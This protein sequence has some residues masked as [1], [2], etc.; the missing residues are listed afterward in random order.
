M[1]IF[2]WGVSLDCHTG[3]FL[4]VCGVIS[5]ILGYLYKDFNTVLA[6]TSIVTTIWLLVVSILDPSLMLFCFLTYIGLLFFTL[7][8]LKSNKVSRANSFG[9]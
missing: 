6:F 9:V 5:G 8:A 2:G 7:G 4:A 1:V 3:K